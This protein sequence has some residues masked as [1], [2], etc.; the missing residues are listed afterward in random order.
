MPAKKTKGPMTKA[1]IIDHLSAKL[2]TTKKLST[3][4]LDEFVQLAYKQAKKDF[5][6]P[7]LGK[8]VV[9][10]RKRR[11][12]RNP[13]TGEPITIPARKVLQFRFAKAAKDSILP[14]KKK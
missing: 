14:A 2:G 9:A 4:F 5:T 13:Q 11:K 12:G 8:V 7:G 1:E 3:Q 10:S 6:I